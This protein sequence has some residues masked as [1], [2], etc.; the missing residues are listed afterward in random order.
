MNTKFILK[1]GKNGNYSI[2]R[3]T[4]FANERATYTI[5]GAHLKF[6]IEKYNNNNVL[7]PIL[8]ETNNNTY[9]IIITLERIANTFI[10]MG[11]HEVYSKKYN[12]NDKIFFSF[13]KNN[14]TDIDKKQ[15]I[16]RLYLKRGC[17]IMNAQKE[18]IPNSEIKN[19]FCNIEIELGSLWVSATTN[20][21]GINIYATEITALN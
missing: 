7:N 8:Y 17:K 16:V 5:Y 2:H 13:L 12:I 18:I 19:K 14:S 10:S 4:E 9:N 21:Y 11:K 3:K 15:Y 1:P 6:G 20:L